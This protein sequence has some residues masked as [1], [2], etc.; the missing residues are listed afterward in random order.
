M[1]SQIIAQNT[2]SAPVFNIGQA[3]TMSSREIAD[4]VGSRHDK[5]KQSIERLTRTTFNSDGSIK[6]LPVI[7]LPPM[8]EYLDPLGRAASE[9][10]VGKRDSY[11]IVAQLSPEFTAL[12]VDR[13]Q[14][15]E[16]RAGYP[17]E[18]ST[19]DIL[20]IAMESEKGRLAAIE[21]RDQA[22]ATKA[23]IG[24]RREATAMATA[25][26]ARRETAKLRDELGRNRR[27]ATVI[28]VERA[29]GLKFPK[30]AY[31]ALR[32]WCKKN[33]AAAVD[34]ADERYGSVKAWPAGAWLSEFDID[35]GELFTGGVSA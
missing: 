23:Q 34:V 11:I 32:K 13:W 4:L 31:V 33:D 28:A 35:L 8:G 14:E 25:A 16:S 29:T 27:H 7:G 6:K 2:M 9:Y 20:T 3:A 15:L 10:L 19:L 17:A 18:L 1:N 21:Q 26:T 5:V 24:S 22:I 12:L 30:N